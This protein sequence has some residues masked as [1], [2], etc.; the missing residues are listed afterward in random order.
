MLKV[1]NKNND[2]ND[3]D[4]DVIL[5]SLLL[6]LTYAMF[7]LSLFVVDFELVNAGW[8]TTNEIETL[9]KGNII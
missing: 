2:I 8:N 1:N 5:V 4:N 9:E 7:C 6:F 3:N